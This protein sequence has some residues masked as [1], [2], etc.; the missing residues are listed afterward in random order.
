MKG[1]GNLFR[2]GERMFVGLTQDVLC[3][4][5]LS[6]ENP[7]RTLGTS[8][9]WGLSKVDKVQDVRALGYRHI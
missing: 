6:K 5:T 2:N 8:C 1:V 4:K 3:R 9:K 7:P